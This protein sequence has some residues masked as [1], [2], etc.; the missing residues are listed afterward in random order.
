MILHPSNATHGARF[1][2]EFRPGIHRLICLLAVVFV[3]LSAC[4]RP[5]TVVVGA[6]AFT[7]GYLLG[8][9]AVMLLQNEGLDVEEQFGVAS[10]AMRSALESGQ[11]DLYY[12][13]TGTAYVAYHGQ[14]NRSVMIDST[15]VLGAVRELDSV[16]HDLRW[17]TP[18]GFDNTYALLMRSSE[19]EQL[20]I[21]TLSELGGHLAK[22]TSLTIAVD[23]EFYERA[24]GFR[25][26]SDLYGLESATVMRMDA[27]LIYQALAHDRIDVGMGYATDGRIAAFDL[28]VLEDDEEYFPKYHPAPVVRAEVLHR[29]PQ[30]AHVLLRL[31]ERLDAETMRRLNAEVDVHHRDPRK[32]ARRWLQAVGLIE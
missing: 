22:E 10:A 9:M 4:S 8:H 29:H 3:V 27:G 14:S 21:A 28:H 1:R 23:A 13:Y 32:V 12:E 6:K 7:E 15:A 25:Q 20:G 24:D 2:S 17:L 5:E 26:L 18:L 19:A 11:I 16:K 30:I 31:N